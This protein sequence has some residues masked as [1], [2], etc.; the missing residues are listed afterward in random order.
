[1]GPFSNRKKLGD[2]TV[3]EYLKWCYTYTQTHTHTK[4]RD[5]D[6]QAFPPHKVPIQRRGHPS[7]CN[8]SLSHAGNL[9]I[10]H[11]ICG[12]VSPQSLSPPSRDI[13]T[14]Q[15][16]SLPNL[17]PP[18]EPQDPPTPSLLVERP[19][20]SVLPLKTVSQIAFPRPDGRLSSSLSPPTL[21]CVISDEAAACL[22]L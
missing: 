6:P 10:C 1:M 2:P 21:L 22:L 3:P 14:P 18:Q 9:P 4:S 20:Q 8:L 15:D 7:P 19:P 12:E 11:P 17:I 5:T 16:K 13:P